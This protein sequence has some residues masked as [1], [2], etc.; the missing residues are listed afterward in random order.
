MG[1]LADNARDFISLERNLELEMGMKKR[2]PSLRARRRGI[3]VRNPGDKS[4]ANVD[5]S[6]DFFKTGGLIPGAC[7]RDA[8]GKKEGPETHERTT[9]PEGS[10]NFTPWYSYEEKCRLQDIQDEVDSVL[11]LRSNLND[12]EGGGGGEGDDDSSDD[13]EE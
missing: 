11:E 13:D 5:Y 4:F 10:V 2:V 9:F 3:G 8:R 6:P 1:R 7:I 12:R